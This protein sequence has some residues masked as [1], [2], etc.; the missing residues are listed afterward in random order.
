M[1]VVIITGMSGAGR[2]T[3]AHV[4]E[5]SNWYVVDNL[6]PAMLLPLIKEVE[7]EHQKVAVVIDVRSRAFFEELAQSLSAL[8]QMQINVRIL[9]LDSADEILVRRYEATRRPHPLQ[10]GDRIFDG[11]TR[12][13]KLLGDLRATAEIVLDSSALNVHQLGNKISEVFAQLSD[14]GIHL[15]L[16]SF[17]YKYGIPYDADFILDCRFIPNP[18][19][20]PE[21][22]PLSGQD[23]AV[24]KMV[25]DNPA[26]KDFIKNFLHLFNGTKDGF[27]QEGKRYLTIAIGCTGGRHR[28]VAVSEFLANEFK[29]QK[30]DTTLNHRDLDR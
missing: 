26:T 23:G 3:A 5:D 11:V 30:I 12:E 22:Q 21:L 14:R 20:V 2:S 28:S 24:A 10:A 6:P 18:H 19:W 29:N 9:F 15:S 27:L 8:K 16:L 1:E 4:L 13:R 17:G 25:L 7:G